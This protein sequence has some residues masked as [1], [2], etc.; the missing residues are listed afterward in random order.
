M[1]GRGHAWRTD[2]YCSGRYASYW[3]AF[4]CTDLDPDGFC[5]D[6]DPDG[7]CTDLDP[8]GFL[9]ELGLVQVFHRRLRFTL[10]LKVLKQQQYI[11][12]AVIHD[13]TMHFE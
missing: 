10:L 12:A 5:T 11:S 1:H 3:N 8:D 4:I 9:S 6:L 13:R 7:F 2:G